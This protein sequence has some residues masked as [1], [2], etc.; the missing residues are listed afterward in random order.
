MKTKL[1]YYIRWLVSGIVM[2]PIMAILDKLG[3][4]LLIV[5]LI[6]QS[7]GSLVFWNID[8]NIFRG[9]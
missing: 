1:F 6:G 7:F 3:L 9:E 5:L 2:Y 8:K 4:H